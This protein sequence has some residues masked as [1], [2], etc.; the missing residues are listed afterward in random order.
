[1]FPQ[2]A[3]VFLVQTNSVGYSYDFTAAV[4]QDSIKIIDFAEAVAPQ[5]QRVGQVTHAVFPGVEG[6]STEILR[7]RIA[8]RDYHVTQRCPI[9]YGTLSPLIFVA[10]GMED[11]A[12]AGGES[13]PKVPLL[14]RYLIPFD[15]KT[16]PFGLDYVQRLDVAPK[17]THKLSGIVAWIGG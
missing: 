11:E 1:V 14:P 15:P 10:D 12:F 16:G 2:Y 9:N 17:L 4:I 3:K 13:N 7:T 8:V 5:G 6:V